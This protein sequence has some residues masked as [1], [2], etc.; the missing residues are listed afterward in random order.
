MKKEYTLHYL[1]LAAILCALVW[2]IFFHESGQKETIHTHTHTDS[3]IVREIKTIETKVELREVPVKVKIQE[4]PDTNLRKEREHKN[5]IL[6]GEI[7]KGKTTLQS[8]DTAGVKKETTFN[9]KEGDKVTF[10]ADG[11]VQVKKK[12]KAGRFLVKAWRDI[13]TAVVVV[14]TAIV[15]Y[16]AAK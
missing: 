7:E 2:L 15:V 12:T 3:V 13:K 5:I 8:I 4:K 9:T 11:N 10:D 6:G 14:A 16:Q 1:F